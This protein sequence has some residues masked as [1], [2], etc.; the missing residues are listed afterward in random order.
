MTDEK[1]IL[2]RLKKSIANLK[3]EYVK[4][5]CRD[6]L[7]AGI[8]PYNAVMGMAS[9]MEIVGQK[10]G[11]NEYYLAELIVAG[12]AMKEGMKILE[13]HLK[14]ED[15]KAVGKVVIG[16]VRGDIHNIGKDVVTML[17][18]AAGFDVI[19]MGVDVPAE[20]FI[21]AI[22]KHKPDVVGMSTLL[23]ATIP[24]MAKVI[25]KLKEAGL[26]NR[27][28]VIIGGAV[29]SSDHAKKVGADAFANDVIDGVSTCK[30][31]VG[32]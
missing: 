31:W 28:K 19:D 16:T 32:E 1:K 30:K 9:G 14:A 25:K 12:E 8:P 2:D 3:I 6:A 11:A 15:K 20:K 29:I 18:R 27:V 10:Y 5:A 21:K 7:A 24:E 22:R 17:L 4:Q 26:R 13:P 23:T